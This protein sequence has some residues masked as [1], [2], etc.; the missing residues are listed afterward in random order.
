MHT[1]N[2]KLIRDL[3]HLRGQVMAIALVV[4]CGIAAFVSMRSNYYSLMASQA[5]YYAEYRFAQVFANLKRAPDWLA[6]HISE[7]PG[8]AA[9]QTRIVAEVTL[10]VE[11]L[12]EPARGRIISIPEHRT[13]ML[14]DLYLVRGRYVEPGRGDEVIVSSAFAG[15]NR[16]DPG[17]TI[18]AVI[19][20]R[21]Q[22]LRIV[23][24]ALSPEYVYEIRA[25]DLFPDNRRYGVMWMSREALA[26]AF[27]M[28]GAFNDVALALTRDADEAAVIERLDALLAKYGG[29]GAY[30][31]KDQP[32][33][34]FVSNEIDELRFTSTLIP[35]I[36]LGVTAFLIHLSLSRLV[37]TQ[38]DQIAVLKAFGYRNAAV[39]FHYLKMAMAAVLGGVALGVGVGVYFGGQLT[40]LYS[41]YFRFPVFLY[42]A[43][44]SLL[45]AALLISFVSAGFGAMMAVWRAVKLPP[46]EAMRPEPPA[47]FRAGFIENLGLHRLLSPATRIIVRNLERRPIKAFLSMFGI[48]LSVSLL[49]VGFFLYYDAIDRVIDVQFNHA[50]REDVFVVFNEPRPARARHDLAAL[51]GVMRVETFRAAPARLRYGH[52]SRRMALMGMESGADLRRIVTIDYRPYTLPPDGLVLTTDLA[53]ALGAKP[54]DRL[55]VEV[56]E[57]ARP[58]HQVTLA[59]AV[60]D[61]V[62]LSAYIEV[63][64][65]N[66]MMREGE[67]ISGA[68]LMVDSLAQSE[69]YSQLK[70]MPVISGVNVPAAALASFNETMARMLGVSTA[71]L[72]FFSCIIAFGMVYNGARIALSE[73]GR[74]LA[75]LRVL[76]F[77]QREIAVMLL[78]EQAI[79]TI[80]AIPFGWLMGYGLS[81]LIT[82]AIDNEMIRLPLT[83]SG[84]TYL[85]ALGVIAGAALLSGLLVARRLQRLDLIEVLKTR[86]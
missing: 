44:P 67:T 63:H 3:L 1:L 26:P 57:G 35:A 18:E 61:P 72:I 58:A 86:E 27:E 15:A 55:T 16:L 75:S 62:G 69:L 37:A 78:G 68:F 25:G 17:D 29:L 13:P 70:R 30:G 64:A 85:W 48:A 8:V 60:D 46:A 76:G 45:G 22:R 84:R 59:G 74:E 82:Q 73:R 24:E 31:R 10:D 32:S 38:R 52:R 14:N 33:D 83:V 81:A 65:L 28:K 54:G 9:V 79:L 39:G 20:G 2:R 23:G 71:I 36:F 80:I 49:V 42:E 53:V 7:I 11:G 77:T 50:Q 21:W 47:R 5:A 43:G 40:E 34:Y 56:L 12:D 51:P 6:A 4:A 41:Q 66:R 19:N